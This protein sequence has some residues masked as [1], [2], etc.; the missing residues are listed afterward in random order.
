MQVGVPWSQ[1]DFLKQ[2]QKAEHPF[3]KQ[4]L[5]PD[6]VLTSMFDVLTWGPSEV[7]KFRRQ[8]LEHW[9]GRAAEPGAYEQ[10]VQEGVHESVKECLKGKR[11]E[12]L[13]E[14]LV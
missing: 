9:T 14:M 7:S 1:E 10:E 11:T 5:L 4:A 12:L 13:K 8:Q 6:R 2:A 3:S